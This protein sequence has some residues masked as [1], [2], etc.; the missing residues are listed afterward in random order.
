MHI[1]LHCFCFVVCLIATVLAVAQD[2]QRQKDASALISRMSLEEKAAQMQDHAAALPKLN[3]PEY[4]WWNEAL[5]GVAYAGKATN[6]P[7]A[8]GLAATWDT[9]LLH[10]IGET[11]SI[12]ARAKHNEAIRRG[13][14]ARFY[15]LTFWSP[16]VNIFRDPRWG[17]G[18]ETYG[19]DPVLTGT[20]AVNFV[21][22]MQGDN[23][24]Y[25]RVIATPKHFAVHS[26]PEQ[27]RHHFN[28]RPSSRDLEDTYLPAF[29]AAVT[30]GHAGSVMCAYNAVNGMPA[31][32]NPILLN[33]TLRRSWG[34]QGYVVSDCGAIDDIFGEHKFT[35][36][37][38]TAVAAAIKA[39]TDLDC[40]HMYRYVPAAV[41]QNLLT[42]TE[43]DRSLQRLFLA[44]M[45]LGILQG[46]EQGPYASIPISEVDSPRHRELTLRAARE[47]IVLLKNAKN[48][49]PLS[50]SIR[51]IAV[52]GPAADYLASIKGN[53]AG[54]PTNPVVP[55]TAMRKQWGESNIRYAQGSVF[56]DGALLPIPRNLLAPVASPGS[57]GLTGEYF[58]NLDL[59]GK[60]VLVRT[61]PV[62]NFDFVDV[63]P[64]P[65]VDAQ[66]FAVRWT[67]WFIPPAP[68]KYRI[69]IHLGF[70]YE[71]RQLVG[72]RMYLDD[73]LVLDSSTMPSQDAQTDA[74]IAVE[75]SDRSRHQI[76]VEYTRSKS[77]GQIDIV[78][79][80]PADALIQQALEAA[81]KSDAVVA[82]VGLSTNL[83]GEQMKVDLPG[84]SGGDRTSLDLPA[85]QQAL[86]ERIATTGKPLIVVLLNGSALSV[87]WAKE[88]ADAILEAWYPGQ[89]GGTAIAE[90][91]SG[92]NNPSGK[93]PVTFYKNLD[94]L[95]PFDDY[96]MQGRTYRFYSGKPL[97]P[98]GFGLSY[99]KFSYLD[100][101]ISSRRLKA[102]E[103]LVAKVL[104]KNSGTRA[105]DEVVQIYTRLL[106]KDGSHRPALKSFAR[107]HLKPGEQRWVKVQLSPRDLSL[108]GETGARQVLPG[109]YEL[110]AGGCQPG[111][112]CSGAKVARYQIASSMTLQP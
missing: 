83:E 62:P 79:Q 52:I 82:F 97:F 57:E 77:G 1:R 8:I 50:A 11:I 5:H 33:D 13:S 26:G 72:Y 60:P 61:D 18:Q 46:A 95:P 105:G 39:G 94:D 22:G 106:T 9:E 34:F 63:S 64:G 69:G 58:N 4:G 67:A 75:F 38:P 103:P 78:W 102:G 81:E 88:H 53:Y 12:E 16:N 3:I 86:L 41:R 32:A 45:R 23:P 100:A 107:V 27:Q 43:V 59:S 56:V 49:L 108:V 19:E 80:P 71:C 90:T 35:A 44:R 7:Q 74:S 47:S 10:A 30:E 76:R 54:T 55:L 66:T 84:F 48:L 31:C 70:C 24:D 21:R 85:A 87:N 6:F 91:L 42:E 68:G 37:A 14:D 15:G 40:G 51:R 101:H 36:D 99:T 96:R 20:L 2:E 104:V 25:L 98:F 92:Q 65:G 112:D 29:R 109:T 111:P 17:R 110:Y 93:L 73:K 89:E 28:G